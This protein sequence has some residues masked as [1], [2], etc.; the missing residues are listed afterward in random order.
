M[1][2]KKKWGIILLI[3]L[4][5]ILI[6][7]A[8]SFMNTNID[9]KESSNNEE[10]KK[11][12]KDNIED[13]SKEFKWGTYVPVPYIDEKYGQIEVTAYGI[14]Y[15][16]TKEGVEF[17]STIEDIVR[18]ST[19]SAFS[20]RLS[21]YN[22]NSYTTL[23][24]SFNDD[25]EEMLKNI[26][27]NFE[28]YGVELVDIKIEAINLT[29]ESNQKVKEQQKQELS[30]ANTGSY[31]DNY[32]NNIN[33]YKI[34]ATSTMKMQGVEYITLIDGILDEK[35]QKEYLKTT[36][37]TSGVGVVMETYTDFQTG[38]TYSSDT[39]SKQW[40]KTEGA[41]MFIDL[42]SIMEQLDKNEH[43]IKVNDSKYQIKLTKEEVNELV[44][45]EESLGSVEV[46]KDIYITVYV[47][48]KY[49]TKLE[50]DFSGLITDVEKFTMVI[51]LL[52]FNQA[53]EVAIP[54]S[55][56]G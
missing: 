52:D 46:T 19:I 29:E 28:D 9:N 36:I 20:S 31:S 33:N 7:S 43:V 37:S 13:E 42:K 49:I 51:E 24:Q 17:N 8:M 39:L 22:N 10:E 56:T 27:E 34:K 53:G 11:E 12:E 44:G 54:S 48:N 40:Q 30:N 1:S 18:R 55:V 47:S 14:A 25:K 15:Y 32:T 23:L 6:G 5:I 4:G 50:Y 35:N 38:Y 21:R 3:A 45:S 41:S 26:N 2:M 16:E